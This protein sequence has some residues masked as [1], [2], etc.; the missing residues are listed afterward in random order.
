MASCQSGQGDQ[1]EPEPSHWKEP[2][3]ETE[4]RYEPMDDYET[5]QVYDPEPEYEAEPERGS[6]YD[7]KPETDPVP[8]AASGYSRDEFT[9][10]EESKRVV[11]ASGK[12]I[13]T[14]TEALKKKIERHREEAKESGDLS[15]SQQIKE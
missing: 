2:V 3:Y 14:D 11:T 10:P 6:V 13:E 9:I 7:P 15:V 1:R 12:I 4:P 5:E 8:V